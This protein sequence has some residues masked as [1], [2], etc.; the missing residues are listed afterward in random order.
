[1]NNIKNSNYLKYWYLIIIIIVSTIITIEA[2]ISSEIFTEQ[3]PQNIVAYIYGPQGLN[4]P[5]TNY[6]KIEKLMT[7]LH[8]TT[9]SQQIEAIP[10]IIQSLEATLQEANNY[11]KNQYEKQQQVPLSVFFKTFILN[12]Q[13]SYLKN[14]YTLFFEQ[15]SYSA[16]IMNWL[17]E[18][19]RNIFDFISNIFTKKPQKNV[20]N[21]LAQEIIDYIN[22]EREYIL[23]D[24]NKQVSFF[25]SI[26]KMPLP[27]II[28]FWK[29]KEIQRQMYLRAQQ[30]SERVIPQFGVDTLIDFAIQGILMAGGGMAVQWIDQDDATTFANL[31]K[32][33]NQIQQN[34]QTFL[35]GVQKNSQQ[36][37]TNV[38]SNFKN[39]LEKIQNIYSASNTL[40]QNEMQYLMRSLNVSQ[41]RQVF[42]VG[43]MNYDLA[44]EAAPMTTPQPYTWYN[45][46]QVGDWQYDVSTNSF[47]QNGL[48][49]FGTPAWKTDPATNKPGQDVPEFNNIFT[50]AIINSA[51]YEIEA[52]CTIYTTSSSPFFAGIMFNKARW[53]SGDPERLTGY[54]LFGIYGS[55]KK[56]GDPTTRSVDAVFAQQQ[57]IPAKGTTK[58]QIIS[59]LQIIDSQASAHFATN[60][61]GTDDLKTLNIEPLTLV[62]NVST[63]PTSVTC[64]ISQQI[65]TQGTITLKQLTQKTI[66]GLNDYVFLYHGIGFMSPGCQ[67]SFKLTKPEELVYNQNQINAFKPPKAP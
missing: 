48:Q 29:S 44:F 25:T 63:K 49:L 15:Q 5:A 61:L 54:R 6:Q 10:L 22:F 60:I 20:E 65:N 21:A 14:E 19:T 4:V 1:M 62:L 41:P 13:I 43:P 9:R 34:W 18:F 45:I 31:S 27:N 64:T 12:H 56:I 32:Q 7:R 28:N 2:Y 35:T 26:E 16:Q 42:L 17:S 11:I 57:I 46:A 53:I 30:L 37:M 23:S 24:Y 39:S 66:T 38:L 55:E 40:M 50:E 3:T 8:T 36:I 59:P 51:A 67:T 52:E 47:W 58:E 33:Q